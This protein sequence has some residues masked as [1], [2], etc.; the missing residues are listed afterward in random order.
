MT[1]CG[2]KFKRE[3]SSLFFNATLSKKAQS[4]SKVASDFDGKPR[5]LRV[6]ACASYV[7]LRE[8]SKSKIQVARFLLAVCS[9]AEL[10]TV[11]LLKV[12]AGSRE[13]GR[14]RVGVP[15]AS[16]GFPRTDA[17]HAQSAGQGP[18]FGRS[19]C[20][21]VFR[22]N[23]P[24]RGDR[25]PTR[26]S[27]AK[28]DTRSEFAIRDDRRT[29]TENYAPKSLNETDKL[30]IT[31]ARTALRFARPHWRDQ[32]VP[33]GGGRISSIQISGQKKVIVMFRPK[34]PLNTFQ[35]K[36]KD[37]MR[38]ERVTTLKTS[39]GSVTA[40]PNIRTTVFHS[41]IIT[42]FKYCIIL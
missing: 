22:V 11:G 25:L 23:G 29:R 34:F 3:Q 21:A 35:L 20:V 40:G 12:A 6:S 17:A 32:D 2:C 24:G 16:R 37:N 14:Q 4:F 5:R 42:I 26:P 7:P 8:I 9:T 27:P 30:T 19:E 15:P 39:S 28:Y 41:Y 10:D 1:A 33:M 18:S 13:A 36:K 31:R 38:G